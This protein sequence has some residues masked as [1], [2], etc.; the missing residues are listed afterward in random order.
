MRGHSELIEMRK[1]GKAP[2]F[3]FLT[4]YRCQTDWFETGENATICTA[5]DDLALL[6]LRCLV[7]LRVSISSP[8]EARA[9]LLADC[10]KA[11]GAVTVAACHV[12]ADRPE[13]DQD[14]WA[15]V[16][17]RAEKEVA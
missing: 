10:C 2:R 15:E 1:N 5:G 4:D 13:F 14:G 12:Q 8:N 17:H 7:G 11:A 6:D 3:V 9:K 16:W